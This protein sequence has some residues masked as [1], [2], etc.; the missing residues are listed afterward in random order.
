MRIYAYICAVLDSE[1]SHTLTT[2][3]N[4]ITRNIAYR[5]VSLRTI[6]QSTP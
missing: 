3:C 2:I 4:L 1:A 5:S 6:S